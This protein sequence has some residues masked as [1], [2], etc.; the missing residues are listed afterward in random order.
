MKVAVCIL[1]T[2]TL[3]QAQIF[4]DVNG[5]IIKNADGSFIK[6]E[7]PRI[8]LPYLNTSTMPGF[9]GVFT[10]SRVLEV[11][12]T[13]ANLGFVA[14]C[15][16]ALSKTWSTPTP[17][18]TALG[19]N[20]VGLLGGQCYGDWLS[21]PEG[22]LPYTQGADLT[23]KVYNQNGPLIQL[24]FNNFVNSNKSNVLNTTIRA[25]QFGSQQFFDILVVELNITNGQLINLINPTFYD[26]VSTPSDLTNSGV[27]AITAHSPKRTLDTF[28]RINYGS[29]FIIYY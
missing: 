1:L 10:F 13:G 5:N 25:I 22:F 16:G 2:A 28:P 14:S 18:A 9:S 20:A 17:N 23:T 4:Y 15:I 29:S 12:G 19:W 7:D 11:A 3:V 24:A 21:N 27:I 8:Y 26:T 6:S